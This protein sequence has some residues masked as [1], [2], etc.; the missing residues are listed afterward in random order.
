MIRSC[1]LLAFSLLASV[2]S[3]PVVFAQDAASSALQPSIEI[4]RDA[5]SALSQSAP[6]NP[7]ATSVNTT[8][9]SDGALSPATAAIREEGS[10]GTLIVPP[11][12]G[13]AQP[14]LVWVKGL[15]GQIVPMKPD[16]KPRKK[17]IKKAVEKAVSAKEC[18]CADAAAQDDSVKSAEKSVDKKTDVT[19]AEKSVPVA[20]VQVE[21]KKIVPPVAPAAVPAP[22]VA[23]P[24]ASVSAA[25]PAAPAAAAPAPA[26]QTPA[27]TTPAAAPSAPA[28][29]APAPTATTPVETAPTAKPPTPP[30]LP[31][32]PPA[33]KAATVPATPASTPASAPTPSAP[34]AQTPAAG[35][36][37]AALSMVFKATETALPLTMKESMDKLVATLRADETKH[38]NLLAY[39]S[40]TSDQASTARRVSLARALSV[41]AYLIDNGINNL[42]INVQ[43]EGDKN[44]GGASDRVDVFIT[45]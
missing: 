13:Q 38:V 6:H 15:E 32:V 29:V 21:E 36:D 30:V 3:A 44:P 27:A 37:P 16:P 8:T 34:A 11:P 40:A 42:R 39:A 14:R 35:K 23:V 12:T 19:P 33:P 26:A 9:S 4:N 7:S 22:A 24:T 31:A 28:P 43:A 10:R 18:P 25:S 17:R 1:S 5:L 41:R 20:P 2:V 45:K